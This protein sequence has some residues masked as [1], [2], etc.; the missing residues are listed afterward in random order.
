MLA[1]VLDLA[2]HRVPLEIRRG[3]AQDG[4][5]DGKL[6][7]DQ[8]RRRTRRHADA[9]V[10]ALVAQVECAIAAGELDLDLRILLMKI[11]ERG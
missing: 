4:P 9:K 1:E 7:R 6:S 2:R 8:V 10:E 3:G 11:G 5:V